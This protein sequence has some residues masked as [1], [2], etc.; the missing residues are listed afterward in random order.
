MLFPLPSLPFTFIRLHSPSFTFTS[1]SFTSFHFSRFLTKKYDTRKKCTLG[2]FSL[3]KCTSTFLTEKFT[4]SPFDNRRKCTATRKMY[5]PF[6]SFSV[7]ISY[8]FS[9]DF[10]L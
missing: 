6:F 10:S 8:A 4:L 5:Q 2:T 3:G 9:F 1:P 7:E